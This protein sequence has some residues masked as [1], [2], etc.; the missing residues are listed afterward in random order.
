MTIFDTHLHLIYPDRFSYPWLEDAPAINKPFSA[1]TYF[2]EAA[3][4]GIEAAL[5]MEVDVAEEQ[6]EAETAF[7]AKV[8]P[9][10]AGAIAAGRPESSDFAGRLERLAAIPGVRGLRRVLH[11]V[12]DEVSQTDL[13]ADNVRR[14]TAYGMTFDICVRADQLPIGTALAKNCPGVQF[15]LDHCGVPDVAGKM[16][17]PWRDDIGRMAEL[18]NVAAKLS[19]LVAYAGRDWTVADLRPFAEHIID[20]FGWNRVVWGSD[21]PVCTTT[22][23]LARW[24][25][26]THELIA[27]ASDDEKAALLHRNATR[28]YRIEGGNK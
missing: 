18:P 11:V 21:F 4:L 5:H 26:A 22:A 9:K 13:F 23:S 8:H 16:L 20:S 28:I 25:A 27:G 24:V 12:P 19:G 6:G 1:E 3:A 17:D 7:M 14:L 2:T 15:I 10:I